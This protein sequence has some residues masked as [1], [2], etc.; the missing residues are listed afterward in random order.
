MTKRI[1]RS[2]FLVAL[3]VLLLTMSLIM[4]AVH[5]YFTKAQMEQL[6]VETALAA[7]AVEQQGLGYL[8][9]LGEVPCRIT[10]ID[11]SGRVLFDSREDETAMPSHLGRQEV[12]DALASGFGQSARYS[13]TLMERSVYTAQRLADGTVLRLSTTQRS[14]LSLTL[15]MAQYI[16][17]VILLIGLGAMILSRQ[18]ARTV[19][20]PLNNLNLD[21][22]LS[23]R[24]WEE[25]QPLLHRLDS[26]QA[27]LR[28]LAAEMK[29]KQKE[30][31]TVTR[32][33]SE[34]LVLMNAEGTILSINPAASRL[35]S[36]TA[37]CLGADFSVANQNQAIAAL[38]SRALAGEKCQETVALAAGSYLAAASPVQ[39]EGG[40]FGVVLL[41]FDVTQKQ[42]SEQLR[43]EF[44]ANVSHELKT[45]LHAI[46][47]YAELMKSGLAAP[48]DMP[49]FAEKIYSEAQRLT[50]LVEDTLR[51]SRLDEGAADL[52]WT[53]TDLFQ[54]ARQAVN[55]LSGPA[56]LGSVSLHLEG[57]ESP[58]PSVPQL[59]EAIAVNL[60]EN[61]VKY[62]LPG[63]RVTVKAEPLPQAVRLTVQD[64]GVGIPEEE[65]ERVFERFYRV[66][67]S[68]SKEAGG[69]GLG[70]SIV[71][72]AAF[73]LGAQVSLA[74]QPGLGTKITVDFPRERPAGERTDPVILV[75]EPS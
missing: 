40:L 20:R 72:H 14:V 53:E 21:D 26:Q 61:A 37:N 47:G 1:F 35:L 58:F 50:H 52:S 65:Q 28:G 56:Q 75:C 64:T 60:V 46:S 34:G 6:E 45:P 29:H 11:G 73:I 69:T 44:S 30:F 32:S 4:G 68:R 42:R 13:D 33:L 24:S 16:L 41:L 74:S 10:W 23:N 12:T 48:A 2:I 25:I 5:H 62:T 66:D 36:V 15:G 18:L 51:L 27:Q 3:G 17:V 19:V 71:K 39:T 31:A 8:T 7:K 70:L 43:R 9:S 49:A 22:P 63:G 67:K 54:A 55:A 59:V 57:T 38:V